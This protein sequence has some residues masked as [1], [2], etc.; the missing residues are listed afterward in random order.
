MRRRRLVPLACGILAAWLGNCA[1]CQSLEQSPNQPPAVEQ[2]PTTTSRTKA[3]A[4]QRQSA[5]QS[6]EKLAR[7]F[8][9]E[10]QLVR[11]AREKFGEELTETDAKF[12]SA[13]VANDWADLRSSPETAIDAEEPAS[14]ASSPTLKSDRLTWL[15][16][17]PAAAKLVPSRGV[18]LRGAN[19]VGNVDLYRSTVP[20]SLTFYDCLFNDGLN[21]SHAKLQ[22]LDIRNCCTSAVQARR[23]GGGKH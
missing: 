1:Y 22:E 17:D 8:S 2:M 6:K 15:C 7:V 3:S 16:T 23:S 4:E 9:N 5:P 21:V 13:V 20:F 11:L 14:W 10:P 18:W 19:I 12:F